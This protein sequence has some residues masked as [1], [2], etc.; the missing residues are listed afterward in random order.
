MGGSHVQQ[1]KKGLMSYDISR[2]RDIIKIYF[3]LQDIACV[4]ATVIR[5]Y[6]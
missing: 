3:Q 5:K 6:K 4:A 2:V 1:W